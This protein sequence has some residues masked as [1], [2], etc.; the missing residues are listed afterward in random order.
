MPITGNS[1]FDKE[2]NVIDTF[3]LKEYESIATAHF[4]CQQ[5]L[6]QQF[7]FYLALLAVPLTIFGL[8][9]RDRTAQEVA[10]CAPPAFRSRGRIGWS[11]AA[12][13]STIISPP[14]VAFSTTQMSGVKPYFNHH[15][16]NDERSRT[17]G[18]SQTG[19]C[20]EKA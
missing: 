20:I 5:G 12:T 4:N 19:N 6:R 18:D 3:M 13:H 10:I 1:N 11:W 14:A 15:G 16:R 17:V 8:A 2:G 9:F 7:R